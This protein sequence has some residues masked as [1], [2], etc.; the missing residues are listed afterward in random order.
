MM[1]KGQVALYLIMTLVAITLLVLLNAD[2]F[3]AVRTKNRLQNSGDAA[4]LAAARHQGVLLNEIGRLNIQHILSAVRNEAEQCD[5]ISL[6]QRK[7]ALLGP[8][9]ALKEADQAARKNGEEPNA[10]FAK[11]LNDHVEDIRLTYA[12]GNGGEGDPYPESYPGAWTDYAS[13]IRDV[14]SGGLACGPDNIEFYD[15][16]GGHLLLQREFYFAIASKNWCWFHFYA[17]N[18]LKTI[19]NHTQWGPLPVRSENSTINSEIFSLHLSAYEGALLDILQPEQI[20]DLAQ[21]YGNTELTMEDLAASTM[22]TNTMQVWFLY[23]RGSWRRWFDEFHLADDEYGLNFPL[24]GEIK[25]EYNVRGGAAICRVERTSPSFALDTEAELTWSAAAKP[26][27]TLTDEAGM[28]AP[29][30]A[31]SNFVLPTF[32]AVRL[33]PLDAVGGRNLAT[34]DYGWVTHIRHHL[35]PYL[36]KGP[37]N[38]NCYYCLQLFTW[39]KQAF[40][41]EGVRWLR[42]YADTCVRPTGGGHINGGGT[43]HGH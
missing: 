1:R 38:L 40:H 23:D 26:M 17:E 28:L 39:E 15:A 29:V 7:L 37:H 14:V 21:T 30:T 35:G 24:R 27:G 16:L 25:E 34:A 18:A 10:H 3:L 4:A 32:Q 8:V 9:Q 5:Q 31:Y 11:I 41:D 20:I 19:L 12:G 36:E 22:L 13:A 42:F 6:E 33:V 43:S 2:T